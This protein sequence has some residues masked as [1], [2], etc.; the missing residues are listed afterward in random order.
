MLEGEEKKILGLGEKHQKAIM[1]IGGIAGVILLYEWYK[2]R[3][4]AS[5]DYAVDTSGLLGAGG[6]TDGGTAVATVPGTSTVSFSSEMGSSVNMAA[7]NAK[8]GGFSLSA[9]VGKLAK[10]IGLAFGQSGT[11]SS[12]VTMQ[13]AIPDVFTGSYST[14]GDSG[15]TDAASVLLLAGGTYEQ[16]VEAQEAQFAQEAKL[17]SFLATANKYKTGGSAAALAQSYGYVSSSPLRGI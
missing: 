1:I 9:Y 10:G 12:Y 7:A 15:G 2:N 13:S 3:G 14:S 16:R 11:K 8:S 4:A 6:V 5:S 17:A